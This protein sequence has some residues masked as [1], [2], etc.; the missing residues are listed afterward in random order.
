[1][2]Y[3][4]QIEFAKTKA[5]NAPEYNEIK[6]NLTPF[7]SFI[8]MCTSIYINNLT[9]GLSCIEHAHKNQFDQSKNLYPTI[10]YHTRNTHGQKAQR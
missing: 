9:I 2:K 8:Q 5:L 10:G 3:V 7:V 6:K 4:I 1:M